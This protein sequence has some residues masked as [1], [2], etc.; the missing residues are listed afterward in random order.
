MAEG[1]RHLVYKE[2]LNAL[3]DRSPGAK[4]AFVF[5]FLDRAHDR[6]AGDAG[7]ERERLQACVV[8]GSP[9]PGDVCAFCRLRD[10][11]GASADPS[12]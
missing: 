6:F 9:T 12:R 5:G 7:A 4:A 11:V 10:R 8:C 2:V 1:N 3:E